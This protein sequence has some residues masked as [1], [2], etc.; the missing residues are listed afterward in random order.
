MGF[1]DVITCWDIGG[2]GSGSTLNAE[3]DACVCVCVIRL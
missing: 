3:Y 2:M 1:L